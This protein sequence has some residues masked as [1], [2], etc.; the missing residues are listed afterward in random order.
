M[1]WWE[2]QGHVLCK[3]LFTGGTAKVSILPQGNLMRIQDKC[4]ESGCRLHPTTDQEKYW[5]EFLS[6][7]RQ[8][9]SA[10]RVSSALARSVNTYCSRK[11]FRYSMWVDAITIPIPEKHF[12]P[13]RFNTH[14]CISRHSEHP[15]YW[16]GTEEVSSQNQHLGSKLLRTIW[17]SGYTCAILNLGPS[18]YSNPNL[19]QTQS[20][21]QGRFWKR[22][23]LLRMFI[24]TF[25]V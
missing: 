5:K 22:L 10:Q 6:T 9:Q 25:W 23:K 14:R 8:T 19:L 4:F 2:V 16:S 21:T 20:H 17:F 7:Q 1:Q 12:G 15:I 24:G 11:D 3:H 13:L 18:L